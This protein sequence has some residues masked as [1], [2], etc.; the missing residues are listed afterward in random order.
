MS[1][2][3]TA[4]CLRTDPI[5]GAATIA[6]MLDRRERDPIAAAAA[7]ALRTIAARLLRAEAEL[8]AIARAEAVAAGRYEGELPF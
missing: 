1:L 2:P 4:E 5:G 7:L 6:A 8:A 3:T